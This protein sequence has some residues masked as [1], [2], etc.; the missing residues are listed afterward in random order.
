[1]SV[2][3]SALLQDAKLTIGN[4]GYYNTA[5]KLA[6]IQALPT[7]LSMNCNRRSGNRILRRD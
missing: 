7:M 4:L 2:V 6:E 3:L 5:T 1:M